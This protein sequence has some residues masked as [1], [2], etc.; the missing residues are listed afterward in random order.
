MHKISIITASYN[1]A[2]Y[3]KETIDSVLSQ[4]CTNWELIIVD[5]G[6]KDNSVELIKEYADKD[7]RIKF[8]Q[9][10]NGENRGLIATMKLGIE[11]ADG[12]Y[13]AFL[14]S[15]DFYSVDCIEKRNKIVTDYPNVGIIYNDVNLIGD[16]SLIVNYQGYL[17]RIKNTIEKT[18]F[19][20]KIAHFTYERNIMPTL[21]CVM[22]KKEILQKCD[23][24]SPIAPW[25][26]WWLYRQ[27]CLNSQ[28]YF[29]NEKLTNWRI[30]NNSYIQD[31]KNQNPVDTL[32]IFNHHFYNKFEIGLLNKIHLFIIKLKKIRRNFVQSMS[33][34]V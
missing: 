11:K 4:T 22:I 10:P 9:H 19:P 13:V 29:I 30:H 14:E 18:V 23:F 12:E 6:S 31:T 32:S 2:H 34:S 28:A 27:I 20:A 17:N 24:D 21:S 8:F 3:I 33:K 26:D 16:E 1:Y 25:I 5:D 7:S 15:D